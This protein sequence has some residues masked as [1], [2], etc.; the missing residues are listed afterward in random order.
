MNLAVALFLICTTV[1]CENGEVKPK[2]CN[3][4]SY[5]YNSS[6]EL[7]K[8]RSLFEVQ[9]FNTIEDAISYSNQLIRE[10]EVVSRSLSANEIEISEEALS[11]IDAFYE[12]K[13]NENESPEELRI[14]LKEIVENSSLN[15]DSK[16]YTELI[17][18]VDIAIEAIYYAMGVKAPCAMSRGFW[19]DA[20]TVVKCVGG[21]V[22]S[23]GLG[24]LAGS[25]AGTI[26]LPIVGTVS[27][28]ALGGWS[29]ALVG[30]ATCC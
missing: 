12:I 13:V 15:K 24:V 7:L 19:S 1:S 18:S 29:G 11:I 6:E 16:E 3:T 26:V 17:N 5:S 14:R 23:A 21:T 2:N 30:I 28:A 10:N 27:G 20:W 25:G 9:G 22:G 4:E 8:I